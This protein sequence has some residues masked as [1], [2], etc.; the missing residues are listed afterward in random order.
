[1][2]L[3]AFKAL[4]AP[5]QIGIVLGVVVFIG[6][7]LWRIHAGIFDDGYNKCVLEYKASAAAAQEQ[8]R[9]VIIKLEEKYERDIEDI[10]EME[11][12]DMLAPYIIRY[13]IGGMQHE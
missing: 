9:G 8:S 11:G 10:K 6:V 7:V 13:A 4:S 5:Y 12:G 2:F 1:M 3:K